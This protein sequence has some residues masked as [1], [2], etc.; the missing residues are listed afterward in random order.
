MK[1]M[2]PTPKAV[3]AKAAPKPK[4][5]ERTFD[6]DDSQRRKNESSP[7][8]RV[9]MPRPDEFEKWIKQPKGMQ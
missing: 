1:N 8:P 2:Y 4:N 5:L 9:D 3:A 7:A 6:A